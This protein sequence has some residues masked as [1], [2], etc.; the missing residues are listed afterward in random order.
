MPLRD[1]R[2]Y[3]HGEHRRTDKVVLRVR[4]AEVQLLVQAANAEGTEYVSSWV[5]ETALRHA[6]AVLEDIGGTQEEAVEKPPTP[7]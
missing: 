2:V 5:R 7:F 1:Y 6:R 3:E 4:P